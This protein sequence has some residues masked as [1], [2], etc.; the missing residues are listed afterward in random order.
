MFS[1][2]QVVVVLCFPLKVSQIV[3]LS[4]E[5]AVRRGVYSP[6]ELYTFPATRVGESSTVKVNIRNNSTDT[7]EVRRTL[8]SRR[9]RMRRMFFFIYFFKILLTRQNINKQLYIFQKGWSLCLVLDEA[10]PSQTERF[11]VL[12]S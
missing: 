12:T 1:E 10:M 3:I 2:F 9:R 4:Q 7:H 5:E 11:S 8:I 6:Q